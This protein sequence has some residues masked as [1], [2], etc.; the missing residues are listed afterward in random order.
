MLL[1]SL[2]SLADG[3]HKATTNLAHPCAAAGSSACCR[4]CGR[5]GWEWRA[6]GPARTS[7]AAGATADAGALR[8]RVLSVRVGIS[9]LGEQILNGTAP[10]G[11]FLSMP[12]QSALASASFLNAEPN[13]HNAHLC[14][15]RPI[16]TFEVDTGGCQA[17]LH[18]H[19]FVFSLLCILPR[20][21]SL[22]HNAVA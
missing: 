12:I 9:R 19:F 4:E 5:G 1:T 16:T 3:Y 20:L 17:P 22:V 18:P 14:C 7:A 15:H 8:W 11:S 13:R 2:P 10:S 6:V 21:F